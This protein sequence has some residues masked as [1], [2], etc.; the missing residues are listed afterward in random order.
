MRVMVE[1][2][3]P[4]HAA[5]WCTGYGNFDMNLDRLS[6]FAALYRQTCAAW[7]TLPRAH[8]CRIRVATDDA[9]DF[10]LG[11]RYPE[12]CPSPTCTQPLN[13]ASNATFELIESLLGECTGGVPGG[14]GLAGSLICIVGFAV[15]PCFYLLY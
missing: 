15:P 13:P 6:R 5:S 1:F 14:W 12:V 7:R 3:M 11:F 2:D 10:I 8:A 9:P 4:G